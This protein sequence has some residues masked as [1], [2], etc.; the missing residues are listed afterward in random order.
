MNNLFWLAG[1]RHGIRLRRRR[2][3]ALHEHGE[4][5]QAEPDPLDDGRGAGQP[6]S[7]LSEEIT[8]EKHLAFVSRN[9]ANFV[10]FL[11]EFASRSP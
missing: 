9:S 2:R 6:K 3:E 5:D 1:E 8:L 7:N 11:V 4:D 10:R